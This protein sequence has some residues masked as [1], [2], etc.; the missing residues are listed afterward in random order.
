MVRH[1]GSSECKPDMTVFFTSDT[2]FGHENIIRTCQRPFQ[3]IA[4]MDEVLVSRWNDCVG[5]DDTVYHLGDFCFRNS[6]GADTYLRQLN[7]KIHLIAGNHDDET[8]AHHASLFASISLIREIFLGEHRIVLCHYPMR[9]W[10]GSWRNSWHLFG[11]VHGRLN[12]QPHGFSLDVGVDSHD[13]RPWSYDEIE[14]LFGRRD[15]PF[16]AGKRPKASP[17]QA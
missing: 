6:L 2:H 5:P 13:F 16:A 10:H 14:L 9:E 3:D 12:H 1:A 17:L 11:H 4:E 15:N 8:V 7:G